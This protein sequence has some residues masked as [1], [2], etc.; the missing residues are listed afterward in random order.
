LPA[1]D[2]L[3][4]FIPG[5]AVWADD[6][7]FL[8]GDRY[9]CPELGSTCTRSRH[10]LAAYD[11]ASDTLDRID[12]TAAPFR[13]RA[14]NALAPIGWTGAEVALR[15]LD[16]PSASLVFFDPSNGDWRLGAAP[17]CTAHHDA[18]EQQAWLGDRFVLACGNDAVEVYDI[19]RD[20]WQTVEAGRSPLNTRAGSALC[21]T[22]SELIVWSGTPEKK[23]N[24]TPATGAALLL[25]R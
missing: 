23:G 17:T 13:P 24:P 16:D 21:W 7:L 6:R 18:Y 4:A 22:G 12:I 8:A 2:A 19:A 15:Q 11:P 20:A 5:G 10:L 1:L 9:L 14:A 25:D 3:R